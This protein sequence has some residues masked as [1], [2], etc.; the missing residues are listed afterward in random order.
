MLLKS[1][2]HYKPGIFSD[3]D[4]SGGG[5]GKLDT[6]GVDNCEFGIICCSMCG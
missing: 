3:K 1:L 2:F 6:V 5:D 4:D